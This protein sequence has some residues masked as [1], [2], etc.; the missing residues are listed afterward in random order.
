MSRDEESAVLAFKNAWLGAVTSAEELARMAPA[1][2][3]L[4]EDTSVASL[5]F[6]GYHR[7]LGAHANAVMAVRGLLDDLKSKTEPTA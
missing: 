6:E 4:P 1:V 3:A 5:D 7:V 2:E